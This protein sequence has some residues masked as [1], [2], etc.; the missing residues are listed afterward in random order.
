MGERSGR[1]HACGICD[2]SQ[3]GEHPAGE[4]PSSQETE[5]QQKR[6]H[7]GR[8]RSESAQEEGVIPGHQATDGADHTVG[9]VSQEELKRLPVLAGEPRG[10]E[11]QGT[12]EDEEAGVAEGEFEADTQTRG[13]IHGL[14]P[15]ARCLVEC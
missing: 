14:L 11:H 8:G 15:H 3:W 5:Y 13:S 9:Y 10:G 7:D 4:K 2:A 12:C 6:Q 1:R